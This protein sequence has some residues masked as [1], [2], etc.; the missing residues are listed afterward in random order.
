MADNQMVK[1]EF[2]FDLGN[3]PA[4]AKKFAEYLKGIQ[5][6]SKQATDQLKILGNE[7]SKTSDKMTQTGDSV[8]KSNQQW[9]NFA[10]ILQDLP[11]GFRGIQNNLPAVIGGFAGMTGG[12]YFAA[13]AV[14]AFFTAWDSGIIKFGNSVKLTTDYAKEAATAYSNESVQLDSLYRVATNANGAMSERIKAAKTLKEEY[15]GLLG[16]YSDEDIALGKADTAYKNLTITLWQYAKAKAAEKSLQEIATEQNKLTI[17]K[18]D[19]LNK[20]SDKYL[21]S[22]S[23][24]ETYITV[25]NQLVKIESAYSAALNNKINLLAKNKKAY[26]DLEV[27]AQ[28]FVNISD[29]NINAVGDLKGMK[30]QDDAYK[31]AEASRKKALADAIVKAKAAKALRDKELAEIKVGNTAAALDLLDAQSK[32]ERIVIDKYTKLLNLAAKYG[33]DTTILEQGQQAELANIRKKYDDIEYKRNQDSINANIAAETK[34]Y[35]DSNRIYDENQKKEAQQQTKFADQRIKNIEAQL[36]VELKLHK[37]NIDKQKEDIQ[38]AM[39]Q[40]AVL[41]AFSFSPVAIKQFLDALDQLGFKL[42]A[43]PDRAKEFADQFNSILSDTLINGFTEIGT[44]LGN[45]IAGV[46]FNGNGILMI[47]ADAIISIGK[48][49]IMYSALVKAAKKAIESGQVEFAIPLGIAAIAAGVALK[50]LVKPKEPKAFANG[51]IISGPT[52]GLMG[53]YPGAKTNPEVVAPLDKLKGMM[54]G[55][56]GNFVLRG[57]DLVLAL[58]RSETSLNLRR[59]S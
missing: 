5:T 44:Q 14:I 57:S 10:L 11:Y 52:M 35:D 34:F 59:G 12:I 21:N 32:E 43:L 51:G 33:Q 48:A 27:S 31:A 40:L 9:T 55:G 53:E 20:Y 2:D 22:L 45:I 54:D 4:S 26:D 39:A 36:G 25:G 17:E 23:K 15:P 16:L 18:T 41:A 3:V 29:Q 19:L 47:L 37:S 6:D 28:K 46:S 49:L 42:A 30:G 1:I 8:K 56:G 13:S 58:N 24:Q 38:K 50:N 7:I